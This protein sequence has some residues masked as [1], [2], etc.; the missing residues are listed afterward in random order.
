MSRRWHTLIS[1]VT[2]LALVYAVG[3]PGYSQTTDRAQRRAQVGAL[4]AQAQDFMNAE[5]YDSA[6]TTLG[7]VLVREPKN[8]DAYYY[9]AP[10]Y[11]AEDDEAKAR[12]VL[13]EGVAKAPM[14]SRLKFF[15]ARV[16]IA[17]GEYEEAKQLID[18]TLRFK[19]NNP[20]GLYLRGMASLATADTSAA[21]DDWEAALD[22]TVNGGK[23][24]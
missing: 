22:K 3:L 24:K 18:A 11:L 23:R 8:Q 1:V 21:L 14:S 19:P 2:G 12:E 4:L 13:T 20:E 15:M 5:Q 10:S 7:S 9:L 6:R 17:A 16:H